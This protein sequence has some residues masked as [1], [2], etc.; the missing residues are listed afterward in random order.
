MKRLF[1]IILFLMTCQPIPVPAVEIEAQV[2][3]T[4]YQ[5]DAVKPANSFKVML[6][7]KGFYLALEKESFMLYG[8]DMAIDSLSIGY[9]YKIASPLF[10]YGQVGYYRADYNPAGFGK[11]AIYMAIAKEYGYGGFTMYWSDHYELN[12]RPAFGAEIGAGLKQRIWQNLSID[13]SVGYRYL[14]MWADYDGLNAA[15][16]Q[17]WIMSRSE[18]FS[19][20]KIYAGLNWEF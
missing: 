6:L 8:Q 4:T 17:D 7:Q 13:L 2:G 18:D 3:K 14:R 5:F 20:I 9:R 1:I 16:Q 11:E 19:A 15:G 10:L 12:Y